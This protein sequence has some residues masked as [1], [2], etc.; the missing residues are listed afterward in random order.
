M[1]QPFPE[2]RWWHSAVPGWLAQ[3][4]MDD[5]TCLGLWSCFLSFLLIHLW[6][7]CSHS[8]WGQVALALSWNL[9]TAQTSELTWWAVPDG[10]MWPSGGRQVVLLL[11]THQPWA[12]G[13]RKPLEMNICPSTDMCSSHGSAVLRHRYLLKTVACML[14]TF[15]VHVSFF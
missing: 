6:P 3:S 14:I 2:G 1:K 13:T 5:V 4:R 11:L 9:R 8:P 15:C 7:Q 12:P 10:A